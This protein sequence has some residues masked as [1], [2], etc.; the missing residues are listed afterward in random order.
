MCG[1]DAFSGEWVGNEGLAAPGITPCEVIV[2]VEI[3]RMPMP[4][5]RAITSGSEHSLPPAN[6]PRGA[7]LSSTRR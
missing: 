5:G 1:R 2:F 4:P 6:R 3:S 7:L